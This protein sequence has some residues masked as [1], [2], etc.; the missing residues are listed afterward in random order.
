MDVLVFYYVII[1]YFLWKKI[2]NLKLDVVGYFYVLFDIY[3]CSVILFNKL[4]DILV[5]KQSFEI[6]E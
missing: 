6:Q 1:N 5:L 2:G 4:L 3:E